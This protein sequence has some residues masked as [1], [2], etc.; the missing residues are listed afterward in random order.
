MNCKH[1]QAPLEDGNWICPSCGWDNTPEEEDSDPV[2][3]EENTVQED[4]LSPD[5]S[6]TDSPEELPAPESKP[7]NQKKLALVIG[8]IV[9][10]LALVAVAVWALTRQ[11]RHSC[12]R[13]H[14]R[15]QRN[16]KPGRNRGAHRRFVSGG[17]RL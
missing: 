7:V 12:L 13:V 3:P 17:I 9:L 11:D 4:S 5:E 16:P 1:C 10:L 14:H 8:G 6:P 2:L 15:P